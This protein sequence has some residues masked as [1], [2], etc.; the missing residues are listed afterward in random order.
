M[1]SKIV[2]K[3]TLKIVSLATIFFLSV[4]VGRT[5]AQTLP[6]EITALAE[7][8]SEDPSAQEAFLARYESLALRRPNL[9]R[10]SREELEAT[11]LLTLFQIE[12]ILDH[13]KT[14]GDIL[15]AAELS[16]VD[17]FTRERA[18]LCAQF[19]SFSSDA[20]PGALP[21]E[22]VWRHTA[23][24]RTRWKY[25]E[26]APSLTGKYA[27]ESP[28][29]RLGATLD[30][31]A[32]EPLQAGFLPDF[33]SASA[34]WTGP[35]GAVLRRVVVGDF[36]ARFG[37]GLV[38]WKAFNG[39]AML[40][41]PG[42]V[43]RHGSGLNPYSSTD[44]GHFFR[45]IGVT[46]APGS[47]QLSGFLSRNAVDAR[48]VADTAFTS[49]ATDGLHRT[50]T[51]RAKRHTMHVEVVGLAAQRDFLRGR[52][53][54]TA[55]AY[56]YDRHN[57]RTLREDNRYQQYDGL[58][59]NLGLDAYWHSPQW[60]LFGEAAVDAHWA[61]AFL[62][63]LI[64]SPS[65]A[66]EVSLLLRYYD[67]SY[68]ATHAGAYSTLSSCANQTGAT[69][70]LR[71]YLNK[72]WTMRLH[73]EYSYYP[74]VRYGGAPPSAWR[75]RAELAG[76]FADG[77]SVQLLFRDHSGSWQARLGGSWQLS[78]HWSVGARAQGGL[79]GGAAY[80]EAAFSLWRRRLTVAGRLTGYNTA[81][82]A[83]RISFYERGLPQS[84]S[85]RQFYG[86]GTGAY[87]LV[88]VAPVRSL[89]GWLRVS[90]DY[91]A[92]LIRSFIPG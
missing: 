27:A 67:K 3:N 35:R 60:R 68:I 9:N 7:Q 20:L 52:I 89:E 82:W 81:D 24:L 90:D 28:R 87:L 45:G 33:V 77:S 16:T 25:G 15:S 55:T 75:L 8:L 59:G 41:E 85:V 78:E 10:L 36:T 88:K 26:A 47:W 49:I 91:F 44:E 23:L 69:L 21:R 70:S 86:K 84:Y 39:G 37:Q 53:G 4:F 32:G 18:A 80:A 48:L 79:G 71:C 6:P 5:G 43:L 11:G 12:S 76:A 57:A 74:W 66:W 46:V 83:S 22:R 34:A 29:W 38:L 72:R 61:P 14:Y 42:T 65:Y 31:D 1:R 17:G 73:G 19:F 62:S 2:G 13:R 40:G 50:A 64:W 56:R 51:E 54:V 58:W 92:F 30:Q 63:G